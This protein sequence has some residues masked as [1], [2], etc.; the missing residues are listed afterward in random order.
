MRRWIRVFAASD[1]IPDAAGLAACLAGEALP[2]AT[3]A[4]PWYRLELSRPDGPSVVLERWLADEEGMRGELNGWA[5]YLETFAPDSRAVVLMERTIQARQLITL[6]ADDETDGLRLAR[7]LASL[8][9]SFY[10]VEGG[11]FFAADG[12]M[13]LAEP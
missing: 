12:T 10:H 13:L 5:G 3:E 6:Q 9:G 1:A 8:D 11:G 4:P 2:A 7:W